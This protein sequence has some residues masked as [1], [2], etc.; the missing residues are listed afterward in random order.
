MRA[1][2]LLCFSGLVL[3]A[4]AIAADASA[5]D[6]DRAAIEALQ[7]TYNEGFNARDVDKIMSCYAPGKRLFVF[8]VAPPRAHT[9]WESFKKDWE[10]V[11]AAFPGPLTNVISDMTINVVGPVAWGHTIES[12]EFT[13]K[14][15]KKVKLVVRTTDIYRKIKGKWLIVEEHNSL[16]VDLVTLKPDLLSKP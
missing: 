6:A 1:V 16:P 4:A 10:E 5:A 7:K 2:M 11:F 8:D 14:D 13:G 3:P 9:S 12:G 15:G